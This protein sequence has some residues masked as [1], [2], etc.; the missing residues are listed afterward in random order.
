MTR[1]DLHTLTGAYAVHALSGRELE[2]FERHLAVC[3]ACAQEVRELR[4]TAGRLAVATSLTPSPL[5]KDEVMRRIATVRQEPPRVAA[6]DGRDDR[7]SHQDGSG[8]RES[9]AGPRR[10]GGRRALGLALAACLAAATALGGAAVWQY[11][12]ASDARDTAGRAERRVVEVEALARVLAA[13]DARTRTG[14]FKDGATGAVVVSRGLDRAAF[15]A[16][17]LPEPPAGRVYQLWF[18]DN[19][20]MRP[21]GLL[22]TSGG[23]TAT[24]LHGPVGQASAMGLTVEPAGGSKAPTTDPVALMTFPSG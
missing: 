18:S 11:R 15:L 13:P 9:H 1:A 16:S 10:R 2:E 8:A 20:T 14:S 17:G 3:E 6:H 19:G 5:M 21:A 7:R 24:L 23:G 22:H 12:Q 4:E